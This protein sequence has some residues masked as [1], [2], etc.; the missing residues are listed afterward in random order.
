MPAAPTAVGGV[1]LT[2]PDTLSTL[3]GELGEQWRLPDLRVAGTLWWY[4]ACDVLLGGPVRALANGGEIPDPSLDRAVVTLRP[5][6][7]LA[8]VRYLATCGSPD[9]AHSA[10]RATL[11]RVIEPLAGISGAAPAALRALVTDA[12]GNLTLAASYDPETAATAARS[13]AAGIGDLPEP[14]FVDAAGRR[15]VHRVSCCMVDR[16]PGAEMC[17]SCPRRDGRERAE[18]LGRRASG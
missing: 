7:G 2:Q 6:G 18:L 8:A 4:M 12:L 10:L 5:D 3:I 9:E 1:F 17:V 11:T 15:F 16:L 14:R 13:L